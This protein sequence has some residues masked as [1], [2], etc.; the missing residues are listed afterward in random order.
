MESE[1]GSE[2]K[3][4]EEVIEYLRKGLPLMA[5]DAIR[6][7]GD[8]LLKKTAETILENPAVLKEAGDEIGEDWKDLLSLIYFS[9]FSLITTEMMG[10][11]GLASLAVSSLNAAKLARKLDIPELEARTI[12]NAARALSFM[13]MPE[14]ANR[15]YIEADRIY[16]E[17][18]KTEENLRGF[19]SNLNDFGSFCIEQEKYDKAEKCLS[20]ALE[21]VK[22]NPD[23]FSSNV[24]AEILSNFGSLETEK[25][26]FERAE[27][28]YNEAEKIFRELAEKD[29]KFSV[30]LATVLN[31]F[32][33][34]FREAKKF[35]EAEKKFSE[36]REIFEKLAERNEFFKGFLG[37]TFCNLAVIY[38]KTGRFDEAE[39][40]FLKDADLK[41][42]LMAKNPAY[43]KN[44]AHSLNNLA[45]FYKEI[46]R[47][48]EA[49]MYKEEAER[50][51]N[52]LAEKKKRS[53]FP[54]S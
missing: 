21:L 31:N 46:G 16:R 53:D 38:K 25:K 8:E 32:G 22:E 18:E 4:K 9:H 17:L 29:E 47:E 19:V 24:L 49:V 54:A 30:D 43:L 12:S 44:Y 1:I 23:A 28:F 13:N 14:R 27:Q 40:A 50:I 34:L 11:D 52:A 36:A 37:D 35:E 3:L 20:E 26:R 42:E 33:A 39:E 51:Y 48:K 5:L 7:S 45:D 2:I 6:S 10:L 41:R 15:A